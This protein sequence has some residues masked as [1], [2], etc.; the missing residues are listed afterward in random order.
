MNVEEQGGHPPLVSIIA[1]N[2]NSARFVIETLES[3]KAQ[4]YA[5]VE[6]IIVDDHSSDESPRM[7]ESW[8]RTYLPPVKY[9]RSA[10]NMGVC[11]ACNRGVLAATGKYISYI[12]TDD[13]MLP[14]KIE[15]QVKIMESSPQEVA[16]L[17]SDA[18]LIDEYSRE[19]YGRFIARYRSFLQI[20]SGDIFESLT[21]GNFI[22][23]M[24]ALIRSTVLK[25]VGYFDEDLMY[26][27]YDLWM[28]ISRTH[29][30]MYHEPPTV[31]YRISASSLTNT[32]RRADGLM[33]NITAISKH[34]DHPKA[35]EEAAKV[36]RELYF[37][38]GRTTPFLRAHVSLLPKGFV[39]ACIKLGL[40]SWIARTFLSAFG[41]ELYAS[42]SSITS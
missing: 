26:E 32:I 39:P 15:R 23:G 8:L 17:F 40:P 30:I 4:S 3:I 24:A 41:K 28:R 9:L 6:L 31:R 29:K 14:D 10:E 11:A 21:E 35:R 36:L 7:I 19:L 13:L 37:V 1:I 16:V 42:G 25:E 22:P 2:Y 33:T 20:P 5:N 27:D 18:Y 38:E 12:A 34:S